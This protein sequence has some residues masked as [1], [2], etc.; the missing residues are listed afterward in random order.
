MEER[1]K[2]G[3]NSFS[4]MR[5][6]QHVCF[7]A[8][9]AVCVKTSHGIKRK[10]GVLQKTVETFATRLFP[11]KLFFPLFSL[12]SNK[13]IIHRSYLKKRKV[14]ERAKAISEGQE[15]VLHTHEKKA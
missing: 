6:S 8:L 2:E 12:K 13:K 4:R 7:I 15:C 5:Q 10:F 9:H 3:K 1:L 11:N 14:V